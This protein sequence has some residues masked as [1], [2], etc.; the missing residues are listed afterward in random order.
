VLFGELGRF[1]SARAEWR[2]L[3][4]QSPTH[5][6]A[7]LSMRRIVQHHLALGETELAHFEARRSIDNLE[8]LLVMNA[9]PLVQRQAR[10]V[11]AELLADSGEPLAAVDGL[12]DVWDRFP[13][14]SVAEAAALRA[15]RIARDL[16]GR[17][18]L[19]DSLFARIAVEAWNADVRR[20]AA[21]ER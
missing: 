16:P 10:L 2:A 19:A 1:E 9:D 6:L 3:Q 11:R 18:G 20:S 4:A 5:E 17:G 12:L 21:D 8:R 15:A 13:A 14:D 7:F